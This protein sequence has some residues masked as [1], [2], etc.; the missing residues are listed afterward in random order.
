MSVYFNIP[1]WASPQALVICKRADRYKIL[2]L[3]ACG[4]SDVTSTAPVKSADETPQPD[5]VD[6]ARKLL[7]DS[8]P[9]GVMYSLAAEPSSEGLNLMLDQM[10]AQS[11]WAHYHRLQFARVLTQWPQEHDRIAQTVM[12][13]LDAF[14]VQQVDRSSAPSASGN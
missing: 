1:S 12:Q 4:H 5:V 13:H 8:R 14:N 11:D 9:K 6:N 7:A 3:A 10:E 2:A